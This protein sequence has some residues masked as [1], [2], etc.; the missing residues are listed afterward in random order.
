[1]TGNL[2]ATGAG[3]TDSG[4]LVVPGTATLTSTG[5]GND[6]VVDTATSV[7]RIIIPSDVPANVSSS[8][9]AAG[10]ST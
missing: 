5:A 1:M 9:D 4:A 7:W 6:L 10:I 2:T 8:P 3:L